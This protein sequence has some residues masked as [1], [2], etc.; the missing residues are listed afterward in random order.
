MSKTLGRVLVG[1]GTGFIGT[2]LCKS[3]KTH[4]YDVTII[5]RMPGPMRLTWHDIKKDGIPNNTTAVINLAGQNVLD[6]SRRWTEGFK[7]NVFN[8]RVET[9]SVLSRAIAE[10]KVKPGSF[11]T[12]SGVGIYKPDNNEVYTEESKT[13]EFD[14]FSKLCIE[15]EKAAKLSGE[16]T[17]LVTIR[18]GVVLGR[19][20]GM[21]KQLYMPF[22][23]GLGGPV[24]P[25]NQYLPWIHIQDLCRLIIFAVQ[26]AS[27]TGVLN[28]V[29]P[30]QVTNKQFTD[31]FAKAMSRPAFFPVPT[32]M[33]NT[34]LSA[35]R[36]KMLTTGQKVKP[37][38]T[39][40]LGFKFLYP[41]IDAACEALTKRT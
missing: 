1:G 4:G 14:F 16:E 36:A 37:Q 3:L 5:S 32:F 24:M 10:S 28:G 26:C 30:E 7:Q 12:I 15:W 19:D 25:G 11:V 39:E 35:E 2:N 29:A 41:K 18:S 38:R 21:I 33:L 40:S 27:V 20:G 22:F 6:M 34:I 8:S 31:A 23:L 9:T 13:Y 17:R